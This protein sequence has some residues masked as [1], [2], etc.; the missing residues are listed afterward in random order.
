VTSDLVILL[1][2]IFAIVFIFEVIGKFLKQLLE[3]LMRNIAY[4]DLSQSVRHYML[5]TQTSWFRSRPPASCW[6]LKNRSTPA[7]SSSANGYVQIL[8]SQLIRQSTSL[9]FML[10]YNVKIALADA[11]A[12]GRV[13]PDPLFADRPLSTRGG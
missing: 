9:L 11:A 6:P 7:R 1:T 8:F 10:L 12:D 2:A 4:D 5:R 13:F 3:I